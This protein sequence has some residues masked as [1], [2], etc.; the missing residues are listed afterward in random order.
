MFKMNAVLVKKQVLNDSK[1]NQIG[2]FLTLDEY[3][4]LLEQIEDLE[5]TIAYLKAKLVAD[6]EPTVS[7]RSIVL[8]H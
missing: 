5:D 3:D 8:N 6:N 1:G 4:A 2:V 7:L